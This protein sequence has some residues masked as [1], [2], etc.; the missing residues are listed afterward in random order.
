[1]KKTVLLA[2]TLIAVAC[3]PPDGPFEEYYDNGQLEE[4]GA[5]K[6]G[7]L[8]GPYEA[9]FENGQ[10]IEKA[11]FKDGELEGPY[12]SYFFFFDIATK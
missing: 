9:Y 12:E 8:D 4:K 1:M 3:G 6:D 7:E 10:L 11:I 2:L 5:Y